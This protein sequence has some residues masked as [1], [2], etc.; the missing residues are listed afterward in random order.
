M[1]EKETISL[2]RAVSQASAAAANN[3]LAFDRGRITVGAAADVIV[4]DEE[5]FLSL[6]VDKDGLRMGNV[7]LS[8]EAAD[9]VL[10][11]LVE[12]APLRWP[13]ELPASEQPKERHKQGNLFEG[14]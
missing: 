6:Q 1:R 2:E 5:K 13:P 4:F 8:F 11:P 3:I 9:M 10:F 14:E 12:Q 7:F